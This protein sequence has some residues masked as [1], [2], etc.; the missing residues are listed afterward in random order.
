[1]S[2]YK[3]TINAEI[4]AFVFRFG[5][6]PALGPSKIGGVE[7]EARMCYTC[8]H[9]RRDPAYHYRFIGYCVRRINR[10]WWRFW[11][12]RTPVMTAGCWCPSW[13]VNLIAFE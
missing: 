12:R 5:R 2:A 3:Q 11:E 9:W 6:V 7:R 10:P 1:M 13:V 4:E 8:V